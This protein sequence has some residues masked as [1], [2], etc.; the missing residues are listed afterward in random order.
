LV[1][2]LKQILAKNITTLRQSR[3]MTQLDLAEKLNYSDKAISKWERGESIPDV[4]VLKSI[5]DLFGVTLD[6]LMEENHEAPVEAPD[7]VPEV[8]GRKHRNHKVITFLSI[9]IVWFVATVLFV[10]L[11]TAMPGVIANWLSYVYAV[12]VTM[13]VW[14]VFNSIW[15]NKRRNYLIISLLMWSTLLAIFLTVAACGFIMWRLF[16]LGI[17][18]QIA[19]LVWSRFQRKNGKV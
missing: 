9:L 7:P 11:D 1:E 19:I 8:P 17:P 12:P 6:Y 16:L 14:L 5:A 10:T 3:K 15:F 4:T 18:G 2:D 13:I